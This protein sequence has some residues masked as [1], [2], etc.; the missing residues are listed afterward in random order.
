MMAGMSAPHEHPELRLT[1]VHRR[2]LLLD[3]PVE[4]TVPFDVL[5]QA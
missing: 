1:T 5:E 2:V 4:A 3:D